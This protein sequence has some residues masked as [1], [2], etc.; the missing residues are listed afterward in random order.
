MT[1]KLF[2]FTANN[3]VDYDQYRAVLICETDIDNAKT[4]LRQLSPAFSKDYTY[5]LIGLAVGG[6]EHGVVI[7]DFKDG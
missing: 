5:K 4:K 1:N 2:L 3:G 6:I 7:E